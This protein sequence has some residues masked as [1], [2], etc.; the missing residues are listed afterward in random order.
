MGAQEIAACQRFQI[1]LVDIIKFFRS[2]ETS[3]R[4]SMR[5]RLLTI[6][7]VFL[8]CTRG[9]ITTC[10]VCTPVCPSPLRVRTTSKQLVRAARNI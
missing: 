1:H 4:P 10:A 6:H 9:R 5:S 2:C 7:T 8:E 3:V